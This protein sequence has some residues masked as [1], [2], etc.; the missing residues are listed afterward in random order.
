MIF[1]E[2]V[3]ELLRCSSILDEAIAKIQ[4]NNLDLILSFVQII[5]LVF[6]VQDDDV[7]LMSTKFTIVE[8]REVMEVGSNSFSLGKPNCH[9]E[10][11]HERCIQLALCRNVR[12]ES[13]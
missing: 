12:P 7:D 13:L 3:D 4:V 10:L 9:V 2:L 6:V 1:D 11:L 5:D 8:E